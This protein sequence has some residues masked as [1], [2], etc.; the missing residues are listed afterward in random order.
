MAFVVSKLEQ[1]GAAEIWQTER[2]SMFAD[3]NLLFWPTQ[4][5]GLRNTKTGR[6]SEA[7]LSLIL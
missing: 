2:G 7:G 4:K 1:A 3:R 5:I 6:L